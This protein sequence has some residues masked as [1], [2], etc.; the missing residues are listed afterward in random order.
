VAVRRLLQGR[1][2]GQQDGEQRHGR[3]SIQ[4]SKNRNMRVNPVSKSLNMVQI[5]HVTTPMDSPSNEESIHGV[6]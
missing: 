6:T 1:G 3:V 4:S 5:N 2:A